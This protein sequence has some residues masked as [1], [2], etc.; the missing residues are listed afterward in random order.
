MVELQ[1]A[2]PSGFSKGAIYS[3]LDRVLHFRGFARSSVLSEFLS[4]IVRETVLHRAGLIKEYAI[5]V[6]VLKNPPS[7]RGS[8]SIVRTHAARLRKMLELYYHTEGKYN[9]MKI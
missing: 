6:K 9:D 4:F 7:F 5:G 1:T 3:E 8:S 2:A